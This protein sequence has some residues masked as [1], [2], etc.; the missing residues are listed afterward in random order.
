MLRSSTRG[1]YDKWKRSILLLSTYGRHQFV[2]IH[3]RHLNIQQYCCRC[4]TRNHFKGLDSVTSNLYL[5]TILLEHVP[6]NTAYT[7][8]VIY[9][10]NVLPAVRSTSRLHG[11]YSCYTTSP[12]LRR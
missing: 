12:P 2:A 9:N 4:L 5:P 11:C 10:E 1:Q 8:T 6:Y 7:W 3:T